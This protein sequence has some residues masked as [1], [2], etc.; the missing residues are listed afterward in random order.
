MHFF[1]SEKEKGA[2]KKA[3]AHFSCRQ[4]KYQKNRKRRALDRNR[5]EF[6]LLAIPSIVRK[7]RSTLSHLKAYIL[8]GSLREGAGAVGD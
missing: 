3:Y 1:F 5:T 8:Y 4:E 7:F 2:K 6:S